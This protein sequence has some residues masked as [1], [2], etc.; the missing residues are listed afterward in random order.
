MGTFTYIGQ[1]E[2]T[3]T[4]FEVAWTNCRDILHR[5]LCHKFRLFHAFVFLYYT[6]DTFESIL[7][8]EWE[9]ERN[10]EKFFGKKGILLSNRRD[11]VQRRVLRDRTIRKLVGAGYTPRLVWLFG[12]MLRGIIHCTAIPKVFEPHIGWGAG[13]VFAARFANREWLPAI[14]IGWF[15]RYA[16]CLV[17]G[18]VVLSVSAD[19]EGAVFLTKYHP[20]VL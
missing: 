18:F 8:D 3:K 19:M 11:V 5:I 4:L 10:P 16:H 12:V 7:Q 9:A 13:S 15:G 6:Q 14:L 17:Y 1:A 20:F 2:K